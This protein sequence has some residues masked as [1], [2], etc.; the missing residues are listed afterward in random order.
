MTNDE[1]IIEMYKEIV[2]PLTFIGNYLYNTSQFTVKGSPYC[3]EG[4][5]YKLQDWL[6]CYNNGFNTKATFIGIGFEKGYIS[7]SKESQSGSIDNS[8]C[9]R[10][11]RIQYMVDYTITLFTNRIKRN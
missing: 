6:N 8:L 1:Y 11:E 9:G 7:E 4:G 5:E 2:D 3:K 10:N